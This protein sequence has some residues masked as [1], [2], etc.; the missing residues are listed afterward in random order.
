MSITTRINTD[1]NMGELEIMEYLDK[2]QENI[3]ITRT[4]SDGSVCKEPMLDLS[5]VERVNESLAYSLSR[6][7][8]SNT[9]DQWKTSG[10]QY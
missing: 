10:I 3:I 6:C 8:V 7:F 4:K 2:F 1:E 5:N 9:D